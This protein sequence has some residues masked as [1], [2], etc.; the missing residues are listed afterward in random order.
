MFENSPFEINENSEKRYYHGWINYCVR[1]Y[2]FL[3]EG[4]NQ[5]N[6]WRNLGYGLVLLAGYLGFQ[7]GGDLLTKKIIFTLG[8]VCL[9]VMGLAILIGWVWTKLGKKSTDYFL[10]RDASPLSK[11][12]TQMQ[13]KQMRNLDEINSNIKLLLEEIKKND[14]YPRK[15]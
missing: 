2:Y 4:F 1:V 3:Q 12:G 14:L 5:L 7:A 13:E 8:G 9:G 15:F 6:N 10:W 11:W